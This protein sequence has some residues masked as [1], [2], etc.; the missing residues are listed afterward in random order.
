MADYTLSMTAAQA[1]A[2]IA[3]N[4]G[5]KTSISATSSK[6]VTEAGI[7]AYVDGKFTSGASGSFT[8]AD[9]KTITVTGGLITNIA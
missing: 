6:T 2:A 8:T 5:M 7:K 1:D 3:A 4:V 9:G